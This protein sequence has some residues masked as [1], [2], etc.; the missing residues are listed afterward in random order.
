VLNRSVTRLDGARGKKQVWRPI[1]E[2]E[3]FRKQM[4]CIEEGTFEIVGLFGAV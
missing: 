3:V 1:F 4:H 2:P